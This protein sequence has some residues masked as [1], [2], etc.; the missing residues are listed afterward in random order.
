MKNSIELQKR[1]HQDRN[2]NIV[3]QTVRDGKWV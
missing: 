2:D 1:H 3:A